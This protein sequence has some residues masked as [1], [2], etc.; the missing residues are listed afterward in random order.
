MKIKD[1][2]QNSA[3]LLGLTDTVSVLQDE[4]KTDADKLADKQV[5]ELLNLAELSIRELCT[6]Y[7]PVLSTCEITTLNKTYPLS[8]IENFIKIESVKKGEENVKFKIISR[9]LILEEDGNFTVEYYSHPSISALT[10]DVSFLQ[11]FGT[12]VAVFGLCAYYCLTK[13]LFEDFENY[14][15]MYLERCTALKEVKCCIMPQRRWE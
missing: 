14:H 8:S 5:A 11:E 12:E 13:G 2:I 6:N 15:E 1:L 3:V 10:D 4:Q 7:V 9:N